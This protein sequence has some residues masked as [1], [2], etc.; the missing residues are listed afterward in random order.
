MKL[1]LV[2]FLVLA[3][4]VTIGVAVARP[5]EAAGDEVEW[6]SLIQLIANPREFDG[7]AVRIIGYARIEFE[8]TARGNPKTSRRRD[9]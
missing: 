1:A 9:H 7:K 5:P 2:V 6:V 8:G 4:V 3:L